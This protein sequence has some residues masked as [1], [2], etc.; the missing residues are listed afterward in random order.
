M[1]ALIYLFSLFVFALRYILQLILSANT[2]QRKFLLLYD[3]KGIAV[4]QLPFVAG[5]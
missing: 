5:S 3:K 2:N 4:A 1:T